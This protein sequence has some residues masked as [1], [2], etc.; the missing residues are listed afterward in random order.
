M[1][2]VTLTKDLHM[3]TVIL[4]RALHIANV[5][6][7]LALHRAAVTLTSALYSVYSVHYNFILSKTQ[8]IRTLTLMGMEV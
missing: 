3:S 5:T 2:T 4:T 8:Q 7:T 6:L 1:A